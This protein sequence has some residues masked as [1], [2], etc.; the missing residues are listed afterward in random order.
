[1]KYLI[2]ILGLIVLFSGCSGPASSEMPDDFSFEYS[3]GAM[4]AEWGTY[5]FTCDE[6]GNAEFM[7]EREGEIKKS[8]QFQVSEEDRQKVYKAVAENNFFNLQNEYTDPS[9]MDGGYST[10][11]VH[12]NGEGKTVTLNN[13]YLNQFENV[14][15]AINAVIF[16]YAGEDA[17]SFSD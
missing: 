14:E 17:Y 8:H 6:G 12:A 11:S 4:H 9:I 10:I 16:K 13:Y 15:V 2:L 1:M 7:A 5:D 3:T